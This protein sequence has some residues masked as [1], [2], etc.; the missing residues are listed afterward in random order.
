MGLSCQIKLAIYAEKPV[1]WVGNQL[2]VQPRLGDSANSSVSHFRTKA[3]PGLWICVINLPQQAATMSWSC[4]HMLLQPDACQSQLWL[5]W[6]CFWA[7]RAS[8]AASLLSGSMSTSK[9]P[10]LRYA[11]ESPGC[12]VHE[13]QLKTLV[14]NLSPTLILLFPSK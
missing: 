7:A 5:S 6:A 14:C 4:F 8:L 9:S 3:L 1:L 10:A 13:S 2:Q 11:S 12:F